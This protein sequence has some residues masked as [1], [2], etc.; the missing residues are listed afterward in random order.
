MTPSTDEWLEPATDW[1]R[2]WAS[3]FP[4]QARDVWLG[5]HCARICT[6]VPVEFRAARLDPASIKDRESYWGK[7]LWVWDARD[8]LITLRSDGFLVSPSKKPAIA[9]CTQ[10]VF[11]DFGPGFLTGLHEFEPRVAR[12]ISRK[13]EGDATL[14]GVEWMSHAK[15]VSLAEEW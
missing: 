11:L 2:Y 13:T 7:M 8:K 12:V 9:A 15:F 3:L 4:V 5:F 1:H 14:W 6:T 10:P